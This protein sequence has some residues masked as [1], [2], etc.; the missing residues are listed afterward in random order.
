[1]H[2]SGS[3]QVAAQVASIEQAVAEAVDQL[4][5]SGTLFLVTADHGFTDAPVEARLDLDLQPEVRECLAMPLTGEPRV[6]YCHVRSGWGE[7]FEQRFEEAFGG[8]ATLYSSEALVK[9][10]WFGPGPVHAKLLDRVGDYT[11]VCGPGRILVDNLPGASRFDQLGV[12]G[13]MSDEELR[14]PLLAVRC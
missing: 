1:V 9:T 4:Q 2:G 10:G 5:G 12:H 8:A 3:H 13:G 11:A 14:V 6:A 7:R